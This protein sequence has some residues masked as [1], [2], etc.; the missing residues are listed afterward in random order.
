MIRLALE[1]RGGQ[2]VRT[3]VPHWLAATAREL[4][5]HK[6]LP[7]FWFQAT[8]R[9]NALAFDRA[10]MDRD[11]RYTA[12]Q[13]VF[14]EICRRCGV[15]PLRADWISGE[16]WVV[17]CESGEDSITRA[18]AYAADLASAVSEAK[19]PS[20]ADPEGDLAPEPFPTPDTKT[21][22]SLAEFT[23]LPETSLIKSLVKVLDGVMLMVLVRGDHQLSEAKLAHVLGSSFDRMVR[24]AISTEIQKRFSANAGSLGPVGVRGMRILA[25]EALRGRR[26]MV[27]GANRD[28]Y[29]LR[30]VTPGEDFEVEYF[31]LR[32]AAEGE[33]C[34]ANGESLR[35][36]KA[37]MIATLSKD[38]PDAHL[39]V[40]DAAGR[41]APVWLSSYGMVAE[42]LLW[43][44]ASQHH[45]QEGLALPSEIAPFDL[46]VTPIDYS[47]DEQRRAAER[48]TEEAGGLGLEVLLDDRDERPGVKLK[49][50]DLIG[51]PWRVTIGKK[52]GEGIVEVVDRRRKNKTDV[53]IAKAA[54]MVSGAKFAS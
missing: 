34:R 47:N 54:E 5:S 12:M 39:H 20:A 7:Q 29:H 4:R 33:T 52:L 30:Y 46:I 31:D 17:P 15:E 43:A 26:N 40:T 27:A 45:D 42:N 32:Q 41:E 28:D 13:Q 2:E 21:I 8:G 10:E 48:L 14:G 6:Q 3:Q 23:G 53:A 24:P 25:D 44:A 9:W 51:V 37:V 36:E 49:D 16:R 18:G 35:V 11:G 22:A 38:A 1:S 19:A 50:A